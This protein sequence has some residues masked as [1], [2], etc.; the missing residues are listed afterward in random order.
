MHCEGEEFAEQRR[1]MGRAA[2]RCGDDRGRTQ[3]R[4]G[5]GSMVIEEKTAVAACASATLAQCA[6]LLRTVRPGDYTRPSESMGG[7]T[8]GQHVR[9]S[10]DHFAA[11]LNQ[12]ESSCIDYDTRERGTSIEA[13]PA[14]AVGLIDQ[15][16]SSLDDLGVEALDASVTVQVMLT[17]DGQRAAL[18]STLARE[19]AFA[20]HHAIHHHAM[21]GAIAKEHGLALPEDFGKAPST[22]DHERRTGTER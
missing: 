3:V 15:L 21:I 19:L 2:H 14:S 6:A 17:G 10:L 22:V 18:T 11:I 1:M 16:V 7:G 9:H 4:G 13:D 5:Q 8:I 20:S 12:D